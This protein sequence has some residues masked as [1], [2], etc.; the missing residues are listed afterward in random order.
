M[1][2]NFSS[3]HFFKCV[4]VCFSVC[5]CACVLVCVVNNELERQTAKCNAT[6]D[7]LLVA[8]REIKRDNVAYAQRQIY[9]SV[10]VCEI[11][12]KPAASH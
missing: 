2:I 12:W 6:C 3:L 11:A 5:V 10:C 9:I 1:Q 8:M 4:S 7:A